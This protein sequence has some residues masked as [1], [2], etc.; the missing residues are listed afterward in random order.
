MLQRRLSMKVTVRKTQIFAVGHENHFVITMKLSTLF[1]DQC[2]EKQNGGIS[3]AFSPASLP[4]KYN[5]TV[6]C[7]CVYCTKQQKAMWW[8]LIFYSSPKCRHINT[9]S[10]L[11]PPMHSC[12]QGTC[13]SM[14]AVHWPLWHSNSKM[15]LIFNPHP[16]LLH[17]CRNTT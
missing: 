3:A 7:C 9:E 12:T 13:S 6:R 1:Y 5:C 16:T 15:L 8:Y 17:Y 4:S 10:T 2:S 11:H 14:S